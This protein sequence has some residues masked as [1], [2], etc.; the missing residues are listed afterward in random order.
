MIK[1]NVIKEMHTQSGNTKLNIDIELTL[2]ACTALY[3]ESGAGKTT[4][5]RMIAGLTRPDS[6]LIQSPT[7]LYF[8]STQNINMSVQNRNIGFVFQDYALFPNMTVEG[9]ILFALDNIKEQ[10]ASAAYIEQLVSIMDLTNLLKKYPYE[11][12]GGQKQRVALARALVRK[13][14]ILLLD[15]P[16]SALDNSMRAKLQDYLLVLMNTFSFTSLLVS[17][18]LLEIKKLAQKVIILKNGM[19][20]STGDSPL[21]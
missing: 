11:I 14:K 13:P 9:N 20:E 16:L 21:L 2:N 17:H 10:I 3:G 7:D 12:S 18:D 15:E 1:V 6:G 8:S 4:L 5:L 19:V